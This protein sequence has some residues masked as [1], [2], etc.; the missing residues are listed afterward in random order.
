[1]A[2]EA[3]MTATGMSKQARIWL[4]DGSGAPITDLYQ[5]S[6]THPTL[7]GRPAPY[8]GTVDARVPVGASFV[9]AARADDALFPE[10]EWCLTFPTESRQFFADPQRVDL[11]TP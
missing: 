9:D 2:Q 1:M 3:Y 10:A 6:A 7:L 11:A 5:L 8:K 4:S